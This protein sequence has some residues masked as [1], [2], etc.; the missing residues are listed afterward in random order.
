MISTSELEE[1]INKTALPPS[2]SDT[3]A[4]FRLKV[5]ATRIDMVTGWSLSR[6]A[7]IFAK[8]SL[9]YTRRVEITYE[10][11]LEEEDTAQSPGLDMHA[12]RLLEDLREFG[13]DL[14]AEV[15][16]ERRS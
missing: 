15:P 4:T 1:I 2:T 10:Y 9:C 11:E 5:T 16:P 13:Q 7:A 3:T 6:W 8:S 12:M 14:G